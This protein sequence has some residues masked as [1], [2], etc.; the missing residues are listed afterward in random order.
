MKNNYYYI[1]YDRQC[2]A[3]VNRWKPKVSGLQ[4][5]LRAAIDYVLE[6][7]EIPDEYNPHELTDPSLP[8]TGDWDF[9][10]FDGKIDLLVIYTTI[11]KQRGFRFIRLGSHTELFH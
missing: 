5:E 3:D 7:G 1:R 8:Y 11:H 9:H 4:A 10:L 6:Y 2:K